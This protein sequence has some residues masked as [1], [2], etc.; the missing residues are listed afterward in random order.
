MKAVILAAGEGKRMYPF[1]DVR[2]K[3]MLPLANK[4]IVEHL[5]IE[6]REAGLDEVLFVAGYRGEKIRE[7]FGDGSKWGL[8][9]RYATQKSQLGTADALRQIA[10]WTKDNFILVN[11]DVVCGRDDIRDI[12]RYENPV[13]GLSAQPDV[14][15]LGV[16]ETDGERI[17]RIYEKTEKP[18]SNLVNAGLYLLTPDI[19]SAIEKTARSKRGEYELTDSIQLLIDQGSLV[20]GYK[21]NYWL[22]FTFP[23]DLLQANELLLKGL[24]ADVKGETEPGAH[25]KGPLALGAGSIIRSGSYIIGPVAIGEGCDIGPNCFIRPYTAIGDRCHIGAAVEIK[26]S[27]LMAGAKAPHHNYVGDSIIGQQCNLGAGTKTANLRLDHGNI[28]C[29]GT[30]TGR[31]KFGALI[32]DGVQVGINA[33][34]DVGCAIGSH[35]CIGPG[36]VV[37]GNILPGSTLM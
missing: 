5:L 6:L 21:L 29:R 27:I 23:W 8:A 22:N 35:S 18:P 33:S 30:D 15:G 1:T 34:I 12:M 25:I 4:P 10:G 19:F 3:V 28:S 36:A 9:V 7:H 26:N 16:V 37:R 14:S 20:T 17:V 11:G 24:V 13:M 31:R 2:P 32:G